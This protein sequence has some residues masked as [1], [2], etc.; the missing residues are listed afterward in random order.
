MR[1]RREA[2]AFV[3]A[4]APAIAFAQDAKGPCP[5]AVGPNSALDGNVSKP[6]RKPRR[7]EDGIVPIVQTGQFVMSTPMDEDR[8]VADG[9]I[10]RIV[11]LIAVVD[12]TGKI[13]PT[14]A[15]ISESPSP[16]LS[17]A[18]CQAALQMQ[19]VPALL[20]GQKV[21]AIYKERFA[22]HQAHMDINAPRGSRN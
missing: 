17:Q 9:S 11:V 7:K 22:F 6:D 5:G 21:A 1:L 8:N 3:L 16:G 18:V 10:P 13:I 20:H 4:L 15:E 2:C 19:F 12:T 14:S